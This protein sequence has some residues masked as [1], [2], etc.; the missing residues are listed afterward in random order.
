MSL[1]V[2]C[3]LLAAAALHAGWNALV[4][5]DSDRDA[6]AVAVA[7]GSAVVGI[8]LVPF[9]AAPAPAAVPYIL[10]SSALQMIYYLLVGL[11]YRSGELSIV[12]PIMRGLAP[13][14]ASLLGAFFVEPAAASLIIGAGVLGLGIISLGAEGLRRS[15]AGI[16]AALLNACVIATYTIVDGLGA[17]ISGEPA[18]YT[19]WILFGGGIATVLW[20]LWLRGAPL[21]HAIMQRAGLG[22]AGGVMGFAAYGIALWAMTLAPIGAVA[23][24]RE[25]SVLFATALGAIVLHERFGAWRW[26]STG[27]VLAGLVIVKL[28][29]AG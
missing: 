1:A 17:R 20:R 3:A 11:A 29:S 15:R 19:A 12:Y 27:L 18:T 7:A 24:V 23:A 25:S 13:L 8:V 9:L 22:L 10:A 28:G 5:R 2:F 4:R 14:I 16:G 21:A 6:S 26:L